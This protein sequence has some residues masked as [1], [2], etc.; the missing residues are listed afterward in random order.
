MRVNKTL[1]TA[2]GGVTFDGEL[3]ADELDLIIGIGLNHLLLTG[4]LP[5][6]VMPESDTSSV[7]PGTETQQ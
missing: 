1:E 5:M 3:N 6:R 4:A 7:G 2:D